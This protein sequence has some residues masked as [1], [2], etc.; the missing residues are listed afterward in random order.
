MIA[1]VPQTWRLPVQKSGTN[2]TVNLLK[3]IRDLFGIKKGDALI[4]RYDPASDPPLIIVDIEKA[5]AK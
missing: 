1:A 3:E 5:P 2:A 4:L